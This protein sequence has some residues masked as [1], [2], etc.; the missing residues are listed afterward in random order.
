MSAENRDYRSTLQLPKTDFPMRAGLPKREPGWL[1]RWERI[2][3]YDRLREKQGRPPFIL[4]DGPP[5]ANGHLHIGHALNKILKDMVVRS[6]QMMGKDSRYVPGWDCHG[7]PIE[8]KIEERYRE[9]GT[10]KDEVEI[11][12]LRKECRRFAEHWIDVQREE[13]K[14]LGVIGKWDDPYLTMDYHAEAVIA[15]EFMKFLMNGTLYQGSKPVMWSTVE[16]TALAEAEVEYHDHKSNAIW[17]KFPVDHA[18]SEVDSKILPEGASI[19]IWT[20]TPWTIP[21]NRA[22]CFNPAIEYGLYEVVDAP[23]GNWSRKGDLL[24]IADKLAEETMSAAKVTDYRRIRGIS[25]DAIKMVSCAHPFRGLVDAKAKEINRWDFRVPLISAEH[26]TE[27]AGTGFVH[28]APSHGEDDYFIGIKHGLQITHNV[29]EDGRYRDDLPFFGSLD[30]FTERGKEGKAN[31]AVIEKLIECGMLTARS[32][33]THA[34]P[35]SWRSKAPLIFRNTQQ[36]FVSIDNDVE[37]GM[38]G[39]GK[40]IRERALTAIDKHVEWTPPT[41]RNRLHSMISNRPDWV[42]SRQRAWGVPLTCFVKKGAEPG[43]SDF[44]LRDPAVNKRI[45]DVFEREGADAWYVLDSKARFLGEDYDPDQ[46]EQIFDI[47][48][49]WFDSGSTHAFVLRDRPDGSSDGIADLYLEGTDQHRGWFHSSILQACGTR[50]GAPYRGVLTHGFTLDEKGMKMAKSLGNTVAPDEVV[51]MYGADILRLWVA[52][53]DYTS[54]LRIGPEILKNVSDSYRRLRNTFR[55][56]LGNL[57]G[58]DESDSVKQ[59]EMPELERWVLHKVA[60]LDRRVRAGYGRYDF[61]GVFQEI[62]NFATADLSAFYFDIRKDALYCDSPNGEVRRA[63]LSVLDI[64]FHRL[65]TWLAPILTFTMEEVWLNRFPGDSSSVHLLDI[66]PSPEE[67]IDK[68]LAGKWRTVRRVR[69]LV[70]S[71]L[72][73]QRQDKVI[74]ASLEA[75]PVVHIE[76]SDDLGVLRSVQF[77]DVCITSSIT[78]TDDPAPAN[79][80]RLPDVSGASVVFEKAEGKKCDRCWKILP[81]VGHLDNPDI[82]KRCAD[83]PTRKLEMKINLNVLEHWGLNL[84]NNVPAVL[85]ELVANAWDADA[86]DVKI[87]INS[88]KK[89]IEIRD[90]GT[91]MSRDEV[92]DRFLTIGFQRKSK[93]HLSKFGRAPMGQKGIGKLSIFSI[94]DKI[95]VYTKSETDST[96]FSL[97]ANKIKYDSQSDSPDTYQP[98]ELSWNKKFAPVNKTGTTLRLTDLKTR[99]IQDIKKRILPRLASHFTVIGEAHNFKVSIN[100]HPVE[101]IDHR[102]KR[103]IEF[104]WIYGDIK[105]EENSFTGLAKNGKTYRNTNIDMKLDK[106]SVNGWIGTVKN[107]ASLKEKEVINLNRIAIYIRGKL[108]KGD[109]LREHITNENYANYIVGELHCD[110]CDSDDQDDITASNWQ[111]LERDDVWANALVKFITKEL[112]YIGRRWTNL[113]RAPGIIEVREIPEVE[114]WFNTLKG[115]AKSKAEQWIGP[116]FSI[117]FVDDRQKN[118]LLKASILAFESYRRKNQLDEFKM[119]KNQSIQRILKEFKDVDNLQASY[120]GQIAYMRLRLINRLITLYKQNSLLGNDVSEK[121]LQDYL[122]Q[123]LWLMD[124]SWE[125]AGGCK[126]IEEKISSRLK[127]STGEVNKKEARSKIV[128]GYRGVAEHH[129]IIGLMQKSAPIDLGNLVNQIDKYQSGVLKV[130]SDMNHKYKSWPIEIVCVVGKRP[131][132]WDTPGGPQYVQNTLKRCNAR[133]VLYDEIL[134][135]AKNVYSEYLDSKK[136]VDPLWGIFEGI[137]NYEN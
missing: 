116:I 36:W 94:A 6:Q 118:M 64:L 97:D 82:C 78:L 83:T 80:F 11:I 111:A 106:F 20:T 122:C 63:T 96:A 35:H 91:G 1:E 12:E 46:Y 75:A 69:R 68:Q 131:Q 90:N 72:E 60:T 84:Y 109:I 41:G 93:Q 70:T 92:I 57:A 39:L 119:N 26:V 123:N 89:W 126:L 2:G 107:S 121:K 15:A 98:S 132:G 65:A 45:I 110:E 100:S 134:E 7:L 108:V 48:D 133:L 53:A 54:D 32:Y 9:R 113:R 95:S 44:L 34:Y 66:P 129:V 22:L 76:D 42:L 81:D 55:F 61:Q 115:D 13:F 5:Y 79:A 33:L 59:Q 127:N 124:P 104:A 125:R 101:P 40:S 99:N 4:H 50:G 135:N 25:A 19:L 103:H 23:E 130:L 128:I 62:F 88:Q 73:V 71:A 102:Y 8:W 17:V 52:Q 49:V 10:Q 77:N 51:K 117:P 18:A 21:S 43:D 112:N 56:L 29:L 74:G 114:N 86:T 137:D 67:W 58:F 30:I 38:D 14:R 85:S 16:K 37:D 3:V 120:Y 105:K 31:S 87:K 136:E 47:L 28:T 27:D 24:A